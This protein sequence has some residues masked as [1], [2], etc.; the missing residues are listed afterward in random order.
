MGVD[1]KAP[2]SRAWKG[3]WVG[4]CPQLLRGQLGFF[5]L[6]HELSSVVRCSA[7]L[8]SPI[9]QGPLGGNISYT[10]LHLQPCFGA[11]KL[12]RSFRML[13]PDWPKLDRYVGGNLR[14]FWGETEVALSTDPVLEG[15]FERTPSHRPQTSG[16]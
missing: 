1:H 2:S 16:L 11:L 7:Y 13:R 8:R 12:L 4:G 9:S 15:R 14:A 10:R 3:G 6:I 5:H